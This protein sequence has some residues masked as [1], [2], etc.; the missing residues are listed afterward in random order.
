[1]ATSQH[2]LYRKVYLPS[3]YFILFSYSPVSFGTIKHQNMKKILTMAISVM[4]FTG[5]MAQ[6]K[7]NEVSLQSK[8]KEEV[9]LNKKGIE[10]SQ[11]SN[12]EATL[13]AQDLKSKAKEKKNAAKQKVEATIEAID[14][15][16]ANAST[17]SEVGIGGTVSG[18]THRADVSTTAQSDVTAV[19]KG[20]I[21]SNVASVKS[22]GDIAVKNA[23]NLSGRV[24]SNIKSVPAAVKTA[25]KVSTDVNVRPKSINTKVKAATGI[26]L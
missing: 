12:T 7:A 22:Q 26:K 8:T 17:N 16:A 1:M 11:S 4:V 25:V 15:K 2:K 5:A 19:T 10:G 21:V 13:N 3:I 24:N 6:Q 18:S 14:E 23:S 9:K 20:A